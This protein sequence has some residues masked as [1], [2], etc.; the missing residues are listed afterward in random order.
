MTVLS[1][2]MKKKQP[3][4]NRQ[5]PPFIKNDGSTAI[6]H[7][8]I[9]FYLPFPLYYDLGTW[10]ITNLTYSASEQLLSPARTNLT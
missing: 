3:D 9:I 8:L 4:Q 10:V 1:F 6:P 2:E 7:P 5:D